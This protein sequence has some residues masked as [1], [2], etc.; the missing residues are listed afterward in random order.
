[1]FESSGN[2]HLECSMKFCCMVRNNIDD[3]AILES[4]NTKLL[5]N[6]SLIDT[7]ETEKLWVMLRTNNQK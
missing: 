2:E 3:F 1:M 5:Q 4:I 6:Y 7:S